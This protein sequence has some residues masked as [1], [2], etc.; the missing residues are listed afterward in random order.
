MVFFGVGAM[1]P[2]A[3]GVRVAA[4]ALGVAYAVEVLKLWQTPWL[5][6]VRHTTMGHLVFGHVLSW[7]NL[8]AYAV[9]VVVGLALEWAFLRQKA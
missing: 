1:L 4:T 6:Q 5:V 2:K 8:V 7:Q 9:G 3:T